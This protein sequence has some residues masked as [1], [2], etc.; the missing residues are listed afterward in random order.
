MNNILTTLAALAFMASTPVPQA[1]PPA[2][3]PA[4]APA[5][6][7][8]VADLGWLAGRWQSVDGDNWVEENWVAPRAGIM[9]GTSRT[10]RGEVIAEFEFLRVQAA[11]DGVPSYFGQPR[12]R[13]A[14]AFRLIHSGPTSAMFENAAHDYPQ[15][16]GY[17]RD[18][19]NLTATIS[20]ADGSNAMSWTYRHAGD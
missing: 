9:L 2:P 14:V 12:G 1:P 20:M 8:D 10:G 11:D 18:G 4:P 19:D 3:A 13:P 16:I 5:T 7:T 6:P 17:Q 15:R